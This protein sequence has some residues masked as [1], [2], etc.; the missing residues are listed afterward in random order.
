MTGIEE[1]Y[2]NAAIQALID[3]NV[4]LQQSK[5]GEVIQKTTHKGKADTLRLDATVEITITRELIEYDQ[6]AILVTEE[7]GEDANP[8]AKGLVA[9]D[10]WPR[11]FFVSDPVDRSFPLCDFLAKAQRPD[12]TVREILQHENF[13]PAWEK[14]AEGP[15]SITGATSAITCVRRGLPI[16]SVILNFITQELVVACDLG[17]FRI[18][19]PDQASRSEP[20]II[21]LNALKRNGGTI[22][23]PPLHDRAA[24]R[25]FVTF[26][27]KSGYKENLDDSNLFALND[28][29]KWLYYREPGGPARAL[30][31]SNLQ[32]AGHPIGFVYS[33][34][35]KIGEWIH[36]LP[37][38]RFATKGPHSHARALRLYEIAHDRPHT[39]DGILMSTSPI[40]SVFRDLSTSVPTVLLDVERLKLLPNPS[41]YRSTLLL[42]RDDNQWARTFVE[43]NGHRPINFDVA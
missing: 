26:L 35:E 21:N 13:I 41:K 9:S 38:V 30:Y 39:K 42:A 40:Y 32:P 27:G 37:F 11:T 19:I 6:Y 22:G 10:K 36:W 3:G 1:A 23:F 29:P 14:F 2:C 43:L 28:I 31:L 4:A 34:G 15:A 24:E 17:I 16:F 25:K 12:A 18:S 33:N 20:E 5:T 8:L 7:R